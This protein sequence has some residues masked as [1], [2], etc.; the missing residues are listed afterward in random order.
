MPVANLFNVPSEPEE[1][2]EFS[3]HNQNE[4]VNIVNLVLAKKGVSLPMYLLDPLSPDDPEE[5]L[6]IHQQAH[7]DFTGVLGI[8]GVDLTDVDFRDPEQL[9]SWI[10]L[11]GEEHRQAAQIL[12]LE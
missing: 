3:F 7:N 4:H 1:F 9:A 12:G 2:S 6:R 8:F 5:F 10:T 11:H